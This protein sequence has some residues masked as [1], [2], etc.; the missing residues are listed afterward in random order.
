MATYTVTHKQV[1]DNYAVI[2]TLQPNQITVGETFTVSG[3]GAPL[4][5][6]KLLMRYRNIC[7]QAP[8]NRVI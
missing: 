6:Q 4:T 8:A 3:M 2:A 7:L 5:G 1:L